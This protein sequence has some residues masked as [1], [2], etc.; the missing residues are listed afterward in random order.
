MHSRLQYTIN[1]VFVWH[2]QG[3]THFCYSVL[4]SKTF[5]N[6]IFYETFQVKHSITLL[7]KEHCFWG[8]ITL[9]S[10]QFHFCIFQRWLNA[11]QVFSTHFTKWFYYTIFQECG[12]LEAFQVLL[13]Y[14]R[15]YF[16]T[17]YSNSLE[18]IY[19]V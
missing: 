5:L 15:K 1:L 11:F 19:V 13:Y 3:L 9:F 6:T 12:R 8:Y 10:E 18:A 7:F 2:S 4:F 14:Y 16:A 17:Q